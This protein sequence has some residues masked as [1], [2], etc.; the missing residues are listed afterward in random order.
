MEMKDIFTLFQYEMTSEK[1]QQITPEQIEATYEL[2]YKNY[3]D[4]IEELGKKPDNMNDYFSWTSK[5]L[6][7]NVVYYKKNKEVK[8]IF[9]FS[10]S[11]KVG[12]MVFH[13]FNQQKIPYEVVSL[14]VDSFISFLIQDGKLNVEP[15]KIIDAGIF[16]EGHVLRE[17]G[18]FLFEWEYNRNWKP[19]LKSAFEKISFNTLRIHKEIYEFEEMTK[20]IGNH[21][22][23]LELEECIDAYENEKF[24]VCA[25]GLGS[26]LEHLLYLSIEK[27]VPEK[28][29]KTN[30]NSTAGEYIGQLKKEPFEINKRDV[31]HLKSIFNYRNSVSHYNKGI[32]SKDMCDHLLGGIKTAFDKYYMFEKNV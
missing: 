32:F 5:K 14:D 8:Q 25:A 21:Q 2:L 27:H 18:K 22:F 6:D 13:D 15:E 23:T 29:I 16:S 28:D 26:V 11:D 1:I 7:I 30:E 31:S 20:I 3:M 19:Q 9:F 24:F 10:K 4:N 17:V 12:T